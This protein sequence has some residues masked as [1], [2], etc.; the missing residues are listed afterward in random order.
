MM[1]KEGDIKALYKAYIIPFSSDESYSLIFIYLPEDEDFIKALFITKSLE[2]GEELKNVLKLDKKQFPEEKAL[3]V[4]EYTVKD[5]FNREILKID[6]GAK[7][8]EIN[9]ENPENIERN[10]QAVR[11]ALQELELI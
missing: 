9:F 3:E 11:K 5:M 2:S 8:I 7:L 6:P 4:F 10:L 1:W